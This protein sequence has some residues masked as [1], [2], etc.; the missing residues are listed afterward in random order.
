ML[1]PF[2]EIS[3]ELSSRKAL[4]E[5]ANMKKCE[6]K[7]SLELIM[8]MNTIIFLMNILGFAVSTQLFQS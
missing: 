7:S 8:S 3:V 4:S 1:L 2:Y 6:F 5:S